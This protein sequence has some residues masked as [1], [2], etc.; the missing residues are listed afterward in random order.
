MPQVAI[1]AVAQSHERQVFVRQTH[2]R[3]RREFF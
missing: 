1:A 3:Y 2:T